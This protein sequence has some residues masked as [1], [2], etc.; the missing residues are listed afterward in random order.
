MRQAGVE[1]SSGALPG[2]RSESKYQPVNQLQSQ[3]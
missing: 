1:M 3:A 2:D